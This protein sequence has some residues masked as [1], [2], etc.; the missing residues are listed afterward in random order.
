MMSLPTP[1]PVSL[2]PYFTSANFYELATSNAA[3]VKDIGIS[4]VFISSGTKYAVMYREASTGNFRIGTTSTAPGDMV[5]GLTNA[6]IEV[7]NAY[8]T[9][10]TISGLTANS[11]VATDASKNLTVATKLYLTPSY[12]SGYCTYTGSTSI[13]ANTWV[14]LSTKGT[15]TVPVL[16]ADFTTSTA[17]ANTGVK[18]TGPPAIIEISMVF[19]TNSSSLYSAITVG[20]GTPAS[21]SG[22][23]T[24]RANVSQMR[25]DYLTNTPLQL[26]FITTINT[27]DEL[28]IYIGS[29]TT[30]INIFSWTVAGTILG[31]T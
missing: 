7:A 2:D 10:L 15:I 24:R 3:D 5:T 21:P 19:M 31:Y 27:N 4:G 20:P 13:T 23:V 30:F 14:L 1:T 26:N 28:A 29:A 22:V 11:A 17:V 6:D 16:T 12:F 8:L 9:N 25:N 18:Y